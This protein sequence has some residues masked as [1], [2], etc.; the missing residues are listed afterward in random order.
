MV[1][2]SPT[3]YAAREAGK[4][5][6]GRNCPI[7]APAGATSGDYSL[8]F[9]VPGHTQGAVKAADPSTARLFFFN[10]PG[11]LAL[12]ASPLRQL[13]LPASQIKN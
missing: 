5:W 11:I 9:G 2:Q 4:A 8:A 3:E 7:F 13:Q 10:S 6:Q 1:R 12:S